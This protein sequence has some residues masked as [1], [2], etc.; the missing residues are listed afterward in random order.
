MGSWAGRSSSAICCSAPRSSS[1]RWRRL[2]QIP[3]V[4]L[5]TVAALQQNF[6][7]HALVHHV[8][9]APL[10]GDYG[11]EAQVPP[12]IVGQLLRAAVQFPLAHDVEA[13]LIHH[14]DS[15]GTVAVGRA[16]GARVNSLRPAMNRVRRGVAGARRQR[17]RLNHFDDLRL[18]RIGLG[19]DDMNARRIDAGNDQIAPLDMRMRRVR[20]TGKR[21]TRSIRNGAAHRRRWACRPAPRGGRSRSTKGPDPPRPARQDGHCPWR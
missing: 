7:I 6:R 13:V 14:E 5:V 20:D 4:Q 2:R 8:G 21:C 9:R 16:E 3:N 11:V 19:V 15:A 12:E 17:F 1:C 10:A 18:A